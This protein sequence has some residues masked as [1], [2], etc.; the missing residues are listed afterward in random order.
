MAVYTKLGLQLLLK[1]TTVV[2]LLC[3]DVVCV[4]S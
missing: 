4:K 3:L 1:K 2:M